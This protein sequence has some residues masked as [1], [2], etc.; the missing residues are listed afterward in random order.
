MVPFDDVFRL[1][2]K[3]SFFKEG[4]SKEAGFHV[5]GFISALYR[6]FSGIGKQRV[7]YALALIIGK[8]RLNPT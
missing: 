4:L 8:R 3:A 6:F 2:F 7:G 1:Y 5:Q